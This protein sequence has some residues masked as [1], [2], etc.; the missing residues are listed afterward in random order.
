MGVVELTAVELIKQLFDLFVQ[1]TDSIIIYQ[2]QEKL[3]SWPRKN[4]YLSSAG[5]RSNVSVTPRL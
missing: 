5:N 2:F 1:R 4:N 3:S